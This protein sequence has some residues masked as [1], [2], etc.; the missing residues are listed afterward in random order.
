[1]PKNSTILIIRH[2]EKPPSGAGLSLE[3]IERA[4][5]YVPYFESFKTPVGEPLRVANIFA[6]K[7]SKESERPV[8]TVRPLANA[9][10]LTIHDEYEDGEPQ[11][12]AEHILNAGTRYDSS[13]LLIC[14]HHEQALALAEAL[15]VP[16]TLPSTLPWPA[17]KSSP[18]RWPEEVFGWVLVIAYDN[19]GNIDFGRTM[20]INAKLMYDD[21]G[22]EPPGPVHQP[23]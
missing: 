10:G 5:A 11:R 9:L 22:H 3:G 6:A 7:S 17:P 19:E 16:E 18:P 14:W 23:A 13:T 20:C 21:Y 4:A 8:L 1:M 2:A 12:L 15:R